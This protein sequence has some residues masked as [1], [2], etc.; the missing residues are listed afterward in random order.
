MKWDQGEITEL[1]LETNKNQS[2]SVIYKNE[3][4]VFD[5]VKDE[6]FYTNFKK[7]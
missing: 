2:V 5:L 3:I 1:N 7:N 4:L 6:P